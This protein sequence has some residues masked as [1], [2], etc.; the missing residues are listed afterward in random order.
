MINTSMQYRQALYEDHR[1][2]LSKATI[3]LADGTILSLPPSHIMQGGIKISDAVSGS[4]SFDIGSAIINKLTL[5][6]NNMYDTYSNYNFSDAVITVFIGL[7][8]SDHTE[9]LKKGVFLADDPSSVSGIITL[10][11]L[12]YMTK[13]DQ[14]YR[15]GLGFPATLKDIVL[16]CCSQCGVIPASVQFDHNNYIVDH[17]PFDENDTV[18][19]RELISYC[20]Q[21][22]GCFARCNADGK[23]E[24][25]WYDTA[26]FPI[27][28]QSDGGY[29]NDY[30]SGAELDGGDFKDYSTGANTDGGD[31]IGL[32]AYHHIYS[33][34]SLKIATDDVVITGIRVNASDGMDGEG[35][36]LKGESVLCGTEGY[37]L[38][39]SS[40]P[41]I[42]YGR[43]ASVA[44]F[45]GRKIVGMKFRPLE[46]SALSNPAIEAGDCMIVTDRKQNSYS[47]FV[48]NLSFT[49]S[50]YES[51]V[52]GA[53]PPARQSSERQSAVTKAIIE[54]R[55][56]AQQEISRYDNYARQLNSLAMNAMGFYETSLIQDDGSIIKY[57]HDKP[58]LTDSLII[59][60]KSIDG[61]FISKDGGQTYI[62]GFDHDGNAVLNILAAIG[63]EADWIDTRGLTA[64]DDM[65][66]TTLE[67]DASTGKV[68]IIADSFSLQGKTIPALASEEAQKS[69]SALNASLGTDEIFRRLTNNGALQGIYMKN[70][71]L[72]V[73]ASYIMSGMLTLGGNG[74]TN[75]SL[76]L[77]SAD[78]GTEYA[79][80][81]NRGLLA[82]RGKIG[83]W[84]FDNN[85]IYNGP[86]PTGTRDNNSTG[87]GTWNPDFAFWAGNGK[88]R[89]TQNGK[90]FCY[91]MEINGNAF[92]DDC[93][94]T[95][96]NGSGDHTTYL[97]GSGLQVHH[98]PR[99]SEYCS[100]NATG[101]SAHNGK[102][103]SQM[104]ATFFVV[105]D[106][107]GNKTEYTSS[108]QIVSSLERW[109]T[110]I[111]E[112][113]SLLDEVRKTKVYSFRYRSE[114]KNTGPNTPDPQNVSSG[115]KY[116]FVIGDNYPL[117]DKIIATN[118]QGID[119]YNA[120]GVL[121][122]G[123][124]ELSNKVDV[125]EHKIQEL[126]GII[127]KLIGGDKNGN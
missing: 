48:T 97:Y 1:V 86:W 62:N 27:L 88:F 31:F 52:C 121:W 16:T 104:H 40:N 118:G 101:V 71:S 116:G 77:L 34:S 22:A 80:M 125:L 124:K 98:N 78:G 87:M 43:A 102:N 3:E 123:V 45:L 112:E 106:S 26:V 72:Y 105:Q 84:I 117:T 109:K 36:T 38:E 89:V 42:E 32:P 29:L 69:V 61:F 68:R 2:F 7:Q 94:C 21:I 92:G 17:N 127:H 79:H 67:V 99:S 111:E 81:D 33:L 46:A 23:L 65:G 20:A 50:G 90:V 82:Y 113:N 11:A 8:L 91:D 55:K 120:V 37:V 103:W 13:F 95:I 53:Q 56:N 108:G 107:T 39:L 110:D 12:D 6:I 75:G 58:L 64:T 41:L 63:I 9:W 59:Y 28:E 126:E 100:M 14:I 57:L 85:A 60:K 93:K 122:G 96:V 114:P 49:T 119:S 24:L 5:N 25:K 30:R 4:G 15:G 47:C 54:A 51:L 83:N 76:R 19:C 44:D 35:K 73:N 70:G 10:E 74:N 18:T 115:K 66:N